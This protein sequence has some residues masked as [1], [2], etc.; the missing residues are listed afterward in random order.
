MSGRPAVHVWCHLVPNAGAA[1]L[2]TVV[3]EPVGAVEPATVVLAPGLGQSIVHLAPLSR[4]LNWNGW[5]TARFEP[6]AGAGGDVGRLS[7]A[8]DD[9]VEVL[10]SMPG[11]HVVVA[12]S[13]AVRAVLRMAAERIEPAGIVA[14][15]PVLDPRAALQRATGRDVAA[16]AASDDGDG[17]FELWG[18]VVS[19]AAVRDLMRHRLDDAKGVEHDLARLSCPVAFIAAECD[20]LTPHADVAALASRHRDMRCAVVPTASHRSAVNPPV[21]RAVLACTLDAL[22]WFGG[23]TAPAE[24]PMTFVEIRDVIRQERQWAKHGFR[25]L[26]RG[27]PARV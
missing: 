5:R 2:T 7:G 1:P 18:H 20:E 14:V 22:A 6:S 27:A 21:M 10:R 19:H 4:F 12:N 17:S 25:G 8:V 3:A 16:E 15:F 9:L 26:D 11:P 24:E 23:T 13:L